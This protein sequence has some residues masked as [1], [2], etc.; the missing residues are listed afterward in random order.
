VPCP[1]DPCLAAPIPLLP[2]V[3]QCMATSGTGLCEPAP[4]RGRRRGGPPCPI[5]KPVRRVGF[6]AP[7]VHPDAAQFHISG[8]ARFPMPPM[9][10][11]PSGAGAR[12]Q[13]RRGGQ[14][15]GG[16]PPKVARAACHGHFARQPRATRNVQIRMQQR[17][18]GQQIRE[19][20]GRQAFPLTVGLASIG[21]L[22]CLLSSPVYQSPRCLAIL[23]E[24]ASVPG[25]Q[26]GRRQGLGPGPGGKLCES[27][28]AFV[29][30]VAALCDS[31]Q[32]CLN[33]I[34]GSLLALASAA[35]QAC[36]VVVHPPD[37]SH[38]SASV[39]SLVLPD[40]LD[41]V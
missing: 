20:H 17:R 41:T 28:K 18:H 40:G 10:E 1:I 29:A 15:Q 26:D 19:P 22:P 16:S 7:L 4:L 34:A 6:L 37:V 35:F 3:A 21:D 13:G 9:S 27:G 24:G 8:L 38:C 25:W 2:R 33:G 30:G 23:G 36:A 14:W 5:G 39:A 32:A 12:G 11:P 31:S